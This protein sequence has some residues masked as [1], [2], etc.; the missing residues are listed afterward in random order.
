MFEGET[1][2]EQGNESGIVTT[3]EGKKLYLEFI[4]HELKTKKFVN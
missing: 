4:N 2:M 3:P 1:D